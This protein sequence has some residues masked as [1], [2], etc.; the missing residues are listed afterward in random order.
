M[1]AIALRDDAKLIIEEISD[2]LRMAL[3]S[4]IPL[5]RF[6]A[7]FITAVAHNPDILLCDAQ[8]IKTALMK[9]AADNLLPDNRE[10]ALVPFNTKVTDPVTKKESW[11]KLAQY[12]PMVQGIRKRALELGGAR[13]TAEC[14]YENDHFDAVLGDDPHIEHKPA[15]LGQPR[16]EIIG[17]YAIFKD[18]DG[19]VLHR[20]IMSKEDVESTRKVSKS[21]N[22]PAWNA[23]FSEM[24]RKAA[25]RRGAKSVPALPDN[26]RTVIERDDEYVDFAQVTEKPRTI[27]HNP[28]LESKPAVPMDRVDT[29]TGKIIE[30][31]SSSSSASPA[32][33]AVEEGGGSRRT[34]TVEA[35]AT[36]PSR[37]SPGEGAVEG[38]RGSGFS[39]PTVDAARTNSSQAS[40]SP[41]GDDKAAASGTPPT[42]AAAAK[43]VFTADEAK[44]YAS[45]L[46]RQSDVEKVEKASKH[47]FDEN[48][49]S[50]EKGGVEHRL[51]GSIY[52]RNKDRAVGK[53]DAAG[54]LEEIVAE[55]ETIYGLSDFPGDR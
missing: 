14:V 50:P 4:N 28:L 29:A 43:F 35:A 38:A 1:N 11:K 19:N 2:D 27:E 48:G 31:K 40:S 16:G 49:R 15:K 46:G 23:F 37:T 22:G 47:F 33:R 25:V 12:M 53:I 24:A 3:P 52:T 10:A 26:L 55:I 13:I 8:S 51:F 5:E 30:T 6:K 32:E 39:G 34:S 36:N 21:A 18:A 7:T 42:D 17:V 54:L 45:W 41:P 20:E 44:K 9:S